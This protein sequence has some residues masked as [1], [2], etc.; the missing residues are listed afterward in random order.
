LYTGEAYSHDDRPPRNHGIERAVTAEIAEPMLRDRVV[1][2]SSGV[3]VVVADVR[4]FGFDANG[5]SCSGGMVM[6]AS[7]SAGSHPR[8]VEWVRDQ[9]T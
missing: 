4:S 8:V 2:N 3:V 7:A 6:P 5:E 1:V 9:N